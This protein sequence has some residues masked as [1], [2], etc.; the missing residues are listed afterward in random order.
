MRDLSADLTT[1]RVQRVK[2]R[3]RTARA[4]PF[5]KAGQLQS[6]GR[7][8]VG[9]GG[10]AIA[11]ATAS[12]CGPGI[13]APTYPVVDAGYR[14]ARHGKLYWLDNERVLFYG[15]RAKQD[16]RRASKVGANPAAGGTYMWNI[17]T[18]ALER[19]SEWEITCYH[20]EYST[21]SLARPAKNEFRYKAGKFG[22]ETELPPEKLAVQQRMQ[23]VR[24]ETTCRTYM[25]S[26]L[27][28]PSPSLRDL[29]ILRE[30]DGY[31]DL[32]P[33]LGA[34]AAEW[35]GQPPNVVLYQAKTGN[36]IR[37]EMTWDENFSPSEVVY[38]AY[39]SAYV[40][41]AR[42]PRDLQEEKGRRWSKDFPPTVY[43]VWS[44][45]RTESVSI[46]Y[47]PAEFASNPRPVKAG[48]IF[49]GG[50]LYRASGLYLFDGKSVSKIDTGLVMNIAAAPDGCRAV[51]AIQ[52]RHLEMGTPINLKLFDFCAGR[53]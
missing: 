19:V 40:L 35:R 11:F 15:G 18:G 21:W 34:N 36:A 7:W 52:N 30:G 47:L 31:L 20:P 6:G 49:G 33:N 13:A 2:F 23:R 5:T 51:V 50:N 39:R 45:G 46:P 3:G 17:A 24:S 1:A 25:R 27:E 12:L 43:L 26:E 38:S 16:S 4:R 48:W 44:D 8:R 14:L 28:P 42:K 32:G 41:R 53:R 22:Q 29:A 9:L 10:L 37:L